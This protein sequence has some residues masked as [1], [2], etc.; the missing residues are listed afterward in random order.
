[1]HRRCRS[2]LRQQQSKCLSLILLSFS[3]FCLF[4]LLLLFF[5]FAEHFESRLDIFCEIA[6]YCKILTCQLS[7]EICSFVFPSVFM[8]ARNWQLKKLKKVKHDAIDYR[9]CE[10][11]IMKSIQVNASLDRR[12]YYCCCAHIINK[13]RQ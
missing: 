7:C 3:I 11:D 9:I 4:F 10:L 5:F 12:H 13:L 6:R 8:S 1:M 2:P